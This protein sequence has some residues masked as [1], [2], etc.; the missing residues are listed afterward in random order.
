MDILFTFLVLGILA[1]AILLFK[2]EIPIMQFER[3]LISN[4]L[5]LIKAQ[6]G[7][8]ISA[9]IPSYIKG[10][11]GNYQV[12]LPLNST[13]QDQIVNQNVK[14]IKKLIMEQGGGSLIVHNADILLTVEDKYL[15]EIVT[16]SRNRKMKLILIT[17]T[18]N[19]H[20][21]FYSIQDKMTQKVTAKIFKTKKRKLVTG[22]FQIFVLGLYVIIFY[23]TVDVS[24]KSFAAIKNAETL[25]LVKDLHNSGECTGCLNLIKQAGTK[26]HLL[27]AVVYDQIGET[28]DLDYDPSYLLSIPTPSN[29][30]DQYI[31]NQIIAKKVDQGLIEE[32]QAKNILANVKPGNYELL[33]SIINEESEPNY[34]LTKPIN[35]SGDRN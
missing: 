16:M 35:V 10:K 20:R 15:H 29:S 18:I 12:E 28:D 32:A 33:K 14:G 17:R 3:L 13:S 6:T 7:S 24:R 27:S 21:G 30:R 5:I 9:I 31:L 1:F 25:F 11:V 4:N 26:G 2:R 22:A 19:K 23:L 34:Y 8:G